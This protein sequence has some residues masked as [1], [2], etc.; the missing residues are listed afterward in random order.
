MLVGCLFF[1][2]DPNPDSPHLFVRRN[3]AERIFGDILRT[4]LVRIL[5]FYVKAANN[6]NT[7]PATM[8]VP[9]PGC[10]FQLYFPL[11]EKA[12]ETM[13]FVYERMDNA[14]PVP[15]NNAHFYKCRVSRRRSP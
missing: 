6:A 10:C 2:G 15:I 12:R 1:T 14:V 11:I 9:N 3:P 5:K 4:S 7:H 8:S 13:V